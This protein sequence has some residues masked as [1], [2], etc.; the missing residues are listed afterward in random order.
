MDVLTALLLIAFV[1]LV[2]LGAVIES[3]R[4]YRTSRFWEHHS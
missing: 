3:R 4:S 2:G 1:V